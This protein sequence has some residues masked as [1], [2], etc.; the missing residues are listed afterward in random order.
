MYLYYHD[1]FTLTTT[2]E[3]KLEFSQEHKMNWICSASHSGNER[4]TH[5]MI[6]WPR[7]LTNHIG[8]SDIGQKRFTDQIRQESYLLVSSAGLETSP[9]VFSWLGVVL[10]NC[11][12]WYFQMHALCDRL[13]WA[14]FITRCQ[15]LQLSRWG[16]GYPGYV[17]TGFLSQTPHSY[18][19]TFEYNRE[20]ISSIHRIRCYNPL[21]QNPKKSHIQ[22]P[23]A[24]TNLISIAGH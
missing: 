3:I 16:S 17:L 10:S 22:K 2:L 23:P 11:V 12:Q 7:K 4:Y 15:T 6:P 18:V 14:I 20:S 24:K 1:L 21:C 5:S 13:S 8:V 9:L 19:S